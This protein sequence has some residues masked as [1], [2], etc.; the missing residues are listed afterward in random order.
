MEPSPR[1]EVVTPATV[2]TL[3]PSLPPLA[4]PRD[5]DLDPLEPAEPE[6]EAPTVS[7]HRYLPA[8][9]GLRAL[10]VG[11]VLAYHLNRLR[12]GFLGVDLFFVLS[13][14]LITAL[15]LAEWDRDRRIDLRRF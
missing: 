13:G 5:P 12:G 11:A 15:L 3:L 14:Y 4:E 8:L 2:A 7:V 6:A 9:D 10:A 1:S